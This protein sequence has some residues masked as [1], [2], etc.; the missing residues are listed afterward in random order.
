MTAGGDRE[1][2]V[3]I[4]VEKDVSC[5]LSMFRINF[6][7]T[8]SAAE[9]CL[10]LAHCYGKWIGWS[11]RGFTIYHLYLISINRNNWSAIH[12]L[13]ALGLCGMS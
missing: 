10:F 1:P 9:C 2:S 13:L 5:C 3:I 4:T 11:C 7:W 8:K 12:V 6:I